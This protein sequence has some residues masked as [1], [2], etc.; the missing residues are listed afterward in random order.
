[1]EVHW[2]VVL[3][4]SARIIE[5]RSTAL[6]LYTAFSLSLNM[7]DISAAMSDHLRSEVETWYGLQVDRDFLV[8]PFS[9]DLS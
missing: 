7:F 9:L 4:A 3:L 2:L 6:D 1:M 5:P 8:W